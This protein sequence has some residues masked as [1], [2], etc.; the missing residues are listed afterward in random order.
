MHDGRAAPHPYPLPAR[1]ERGAKR[2]TF[3]GDG[4]VC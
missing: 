4:N 3:M 2:R 1:G